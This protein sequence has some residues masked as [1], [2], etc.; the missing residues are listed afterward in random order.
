MRLWIGN[1]LISIPFKV[2][3]KQ[4]GYEE[5]GSDGKI[6]IPFKVRLKQI[7]RKPYSIHRKFQFHLRYD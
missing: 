6:S 7:R 5:V 2:R 4:G 3:L 1:L